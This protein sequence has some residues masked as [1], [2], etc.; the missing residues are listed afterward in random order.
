MATNTTPSVAL[1]TDQIEQY[2]RDGF[3]IVRNVFSDEEMRA[4]ADES[5]ALLDRK[6][7]IDTANI[8]CR[9]QN[10]C[11]TSECTFDCFDP[12]IDI[13]PVAKYF[14]YAPRMFAI[15]KDLYGEEAFLFK[16]KMI[17]KHANIPGYALHQ[18][19]IGWESFPESFLTV[20]VAI[21]QTNAE[22]GA[23]EV[24]PGYHQGGYM[25]PRDG[26]YHELPLSAIDESKGVILNLEPGDI[27]I[28]SGFTPH[29]SGPNLS[30][31][32]RRQLY[33]SYSS[34]SDGGEQRTQHYTEF[35][36]WL[37]EKYAQYGKTDV[38][39]R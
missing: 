39:F 6:D 7:L 20:I 26:E 31:R 35:H 24:F 1:S 23:T 19:F 13:A 5:E 9:W 10:H 18:D 17:F 38:Y 15:L 29:R 34:A 33:L 11:G 36:T 12:V 3:L 22:N 37:K 27:A 4:L 8:R 32:P 14:A 25:S 28:F 21:D 16:D 2:H 30:D